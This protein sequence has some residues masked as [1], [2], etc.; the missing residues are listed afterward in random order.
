MRNTKLV[1][2]GLA[3]AAGGA[4]AVLSCSDDAPMDADAQAVCD[5]EGFEPT[6]TA[7]KVYRVRDLSALPTP[8]SEQKWSSAICEAGDVV[9]GGGCYTF[10]DGIA[11]DADNPPEAPEVDYRLLMS[12]PRRFHDGSGALTGTEEGWDCVWDNTLGGNGPRFEAA[13]ICLDIVE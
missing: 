8:I 12:G 5:C 2:F 6:L 9:V 4:A 3:C 10:H 11:V 7:D 1:L 13:A